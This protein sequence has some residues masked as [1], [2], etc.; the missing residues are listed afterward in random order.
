MNNT[1]TK[2][3][4]QRVNE[5]FPSCNELMN[6]PKYGMQ[7]LLDPLRRFA[8]SNSN[9]W[10]GVAMA[11]NKMIGEMTGKPFYE[12]YGFPNEV[13]NAGVLPAHGEAIEVDFEEFNALIKIIMIF[14]MGCVTPTDEQIDAY[15]DLTCINRF[16]K[17]LN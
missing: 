3:A 14:N 15:H 8:F 16:Y 13:G 10:E 2:T 1:K 5:V 7:Y 11:V 9:Q 4:V 6:D 12:W 17:I